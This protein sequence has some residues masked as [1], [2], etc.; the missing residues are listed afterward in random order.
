M[1]IILDFDST[2]VDTHTAV[3]K[4]YR[5]TT[6]DYSTA[7]TDDSG[8]SIKEICPLWSEEECASV[9]KN[10]RLF[11]LMKPF[12]GAVEATKKLQED[13]HRITIC[14]VHG[15]EGIL[16]KGQAI[17]RMFS[18]IKEVIYIDNNTIMNKDLIRADVIVDDHMKNLNSSKCRNKICFGWYKWNED[19]VGMKT[20][21]WTSVYL[22]IRGIEAMGKYDKE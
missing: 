15:H 18:H 19:W 13:G 16:Y 14:T 17:K 10:P 20:N 7:I 3:L 11:E 21:D 5:E 12:E 1:N 9:F 22:L 2:L 6:N 4:L 8:W